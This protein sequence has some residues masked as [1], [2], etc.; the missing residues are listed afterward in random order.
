MPLYGALWR[1]L[2]GTCDLSVHLTGDTGMGKSELAALVQ[3]HW[4]KAMNA[5]SLPASWTSTANALEVLA[6]QAKDAILVID[7]FCPRGSPAE[8]SQLHGKADRVLRAQGN[9]SA[10]QRLDRTGRDRPAKP[11]RGLIVST[12]EDIPQGQSLRAR[13]CILEVDP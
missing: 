5:K 6:F 3:Q 1:A 2:L 7:D 9:R 11:P 4:G 10:R 8:V 12:G 13:I